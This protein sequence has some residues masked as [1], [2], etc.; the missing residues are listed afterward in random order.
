M[1]SRRAFWFSGEGRSARWRGAVSRGGEGWLWL[2]GRGRWKRIWCS[3]AGKRAR[4]RIR[5]RRAVQVSLEGVV[6][7]GRREDSIAARRAA[8]ESQGRWRAQR[9]EKDDRCSDLGVAVVL[10]LRERDS[11]VAGVRAA[12]G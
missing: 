1:C 11:W 12:G 6:G 2:R 7:M 10:A 5:G 3:V 4:V 8:L 9:K